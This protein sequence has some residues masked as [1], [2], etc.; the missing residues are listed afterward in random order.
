[1][2]L[3]GQTAWESRTPLPHPSYKNPLKPYQGPEGIFAFG[4]N[5]VL[6]RIPGV[7]DFQVDDTVSHRLPQ[8]DLH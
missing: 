4:V 8:T 7:E 1:M 3:R 5:R 2:V 6:I